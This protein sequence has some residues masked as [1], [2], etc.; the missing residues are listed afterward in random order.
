M[1]W[2]LHDA[3]QKKESKAAKSEVAQPK[4]DLVRSEAYRRLVAMGACEHCKA[5]GHSQAAHLPPEGKAI[6]VSDLDTFALCTVRPDGAGGLYE[7][8]HGQFDQ[9][10]LFPREQAIKKARVWIR[11][12]Q[13][14]VYASGKWPKNVPVPAWLEKEHAKKKPS[15]EGQAGPAGRAD[16]GRDLKQSAVRA[17]AGAAV[18]RRD[19]GGAARAAGG[20]RK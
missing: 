4:D 18:R 19:T 5:S 8:C 11:A 6:K 2:A 1:A 9:Y 20:K 7:G 13:R 14:R 10:H 15:N 16:P 12:T 17:R 3:A